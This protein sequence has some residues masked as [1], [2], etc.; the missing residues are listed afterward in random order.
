MGR[1]LNEILNELPEAEQAEI[2]AAANSKIEEMLREAGNLGAIRKALGKT[3]VHVAEKLGVKQNAISQLEKRQDI[4]LSTFKKFLKT[5]GMELEMVLV[6]KNGDRYALTNFDPSKG[7]ENLLAENGGSAQASVRRAP[8][9]ST[10]RKA[11]AATK[12]APRRRATTSATP[13]KKKVTARRA[14]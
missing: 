9:N 11:A 4:Y 6:A 13:A 2:R 3:Q 14:R 12:H 10:V 8:P 1:T 5:L 7:I